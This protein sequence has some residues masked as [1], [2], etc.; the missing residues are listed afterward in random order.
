MEVKIRKL[1][2]IEIQ[3]LDIIARKN[4]CSREQLV[5][6]ILSQYLINQLNLEEHKNFFDIKISEVITVLE[7]NNDVYSK[8][9]EQLE[10]KGGS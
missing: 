1:T 5:T 2:P 6:D 8:V 9:I 4:K 10:E 7:K 3:N